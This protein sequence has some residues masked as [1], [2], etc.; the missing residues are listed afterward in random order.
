[1]ASLCDLSKIKSLT[2]IDLKN[3]IQLLSQV[4]D[5]WAASGIPEDII[6]KAKATNPWFDEASIS[7]AVE[8]IA[9]KYL[10]ESVLTAWAKS[11]N[12]ANSDP[13]KVGLILAGNIPF[14]GIHDLISVFIAG[15]ISLYKPSDRDTVLIDFFVKSLSE[16]NASANQYFSKID[17]LLQYDAV[18]A[19]GSDASAK[20][21]KK[22]FSKVP[23]IIR[24]NRNGVAVVYNNSSEQDMALLA[25]DILGYY[26]LGCRSVSKVYLEKGVE[27]GKIFEALEAHKNVIN[28]HK[29]CNNYDYSYA[30]YLLNQEEFY[31]NDFL[32][33]RPH[34]TLTSRI[35]CL[36]YE[37]FDSTDTLENNLNELSEDIQ[38][39][40]SDR[41]IGKCNVIP[42]GSCQKPGLSDYADR[43]DTL[44]FLS[45]L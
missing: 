4:G 30:L 40:V 23:H 33:M 37:Y 36:H 39:I 45:N 18:I 20:H 13:K 10:S 21:F 26:G 44:E 35:A 28:H 27:Y 14:V 34:H 32:I 8:S 1:M 7:A 43:V 22:Y 3:R 11:Y 38:C 25:E 6:R 41:E 24:R 17:R 42:F 9:T 29:Y 2:L 15:H 16:K 19:T 5:D 31:T 12:I